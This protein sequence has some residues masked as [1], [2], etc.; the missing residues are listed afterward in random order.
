MQNDS[1]RQLNT[2]KNMRLVDDNFTDYLDEKF[3]VFLDKS[4]GC[5][6]F[7]HTFSNKLFSLDSRE[8]EPYSAADQ[9]KTKKLYDI[10]TS[11]DGSIGF[12]LDILKLLN[13]TQAEERFS[14]L[15]L[16]PIHMA[17]DVYDKLLIG[18]LMVATK[19]KLGFSYLDK[20]RCRSLQI[21]VSSYLTRKELEHQR[22][23]SKQLVRKSREAR[24]NLTLERDRI[25]D[26]TFGYVQE[27]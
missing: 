23:V 9:V 2:L 3:A 11:L 7:T 18:L 27:Y 24:K 26:R 13:Q 19:R 22:R 17:V 21:G 8:A 16:A 10:S 4:T 14:D 6:L 15:M 1:S 12:D 25:L 20:V 5:F